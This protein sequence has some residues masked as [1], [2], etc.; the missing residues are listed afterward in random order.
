MVIFLSVINNPLSPNGD[1]NEIS[2]YIVTTYLNI[3]VMRI[4]EVITKD[5]MSWYLDKLIRLYFSHKKY[6]EN[7]KENTHFYIGA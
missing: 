1:E 5:K 6:L 3:Q 2:L 7:N 4:V